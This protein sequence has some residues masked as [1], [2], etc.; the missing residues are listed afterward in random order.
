MVDHRTD[1][2]SLGVTLY[3]LLALRRPFEGDTREQLL[4]SVRSVEPVSLRRLDSGIPKDLQTICLKAMDKEPSGRYQTAAAMA[5]DL[6]RF[7]DGRPILSRPA[8]PLI[9]AY[10]W[11]RRH[12]ALSAAILSFAVACMLGAGLYWSVTSAREQK[13]A[14][15]LQA[16][17]TEADQLL[18]E[19]YDRIV[20]F[21]Y[22]I[23]REIYEKV[24]KAKMLGADPATVRLLKGILHFANTD[25]PAA[26]K[27]LKGVLAIEPTNA[28]ALYMLACTYDRMHKV[29]EADQFLAQADAIEEKT[30]GAWFFRGLAYHYRAPDEALE[31]Y[32]RARQMRISEGKEFLQ[33][34]LQLARIHNQRMYA[35]RSMDDFAAAIDA[36]KRL[37]EFK[38]YEYYPYYI[39]STAHRLAAEIYAG[40]RGTR[41]DSIV[42]HHYDEA[43]AAARQGQAVSP[44]NASA[45]SAE[46]LCLE[47][48]G[49]FEDAIAV[50]GKTIELGGNPMRTC[51]AHHYRWRL[52]FWMG[53]YEDALRD[54][55][56]HADCVGPDDKFYRHVY[57]LIVYAEMGDLQRAVE[58][59]YAITNDNLND[60][61]AVIWTAT[62]LNLLGRP[63]GA[64]E[65]LDRCLVNGVGNTGAEPW[66]TEEWVD[67]L[68]QLVYGDNTYDE[69][70][71]LVTDDSFQWKMRGEADFHAAAASLAVGDRK[72]ALEYLWKAFRSFDSEQAYTFHA[73]ILLEKM[74]RDSGWPGWIP[75][76]TLDFQGADPVQLE[77]IQ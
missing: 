59:A 19:A 28:E 69:L 31:S 35:T 18:Q 30:P 47:S 61:L 29:A 56:I 5:E 58:E 70:M 13:E 76:F 22:R 53:R 21:D 25:R 77:E 14:H 32:S 65:H 17:Q 39:L 45:Y 60:P 3:E 48:M 55:A 52:E 10:K 54:I 12:K 49:R 7:A 46:A 1:I 16:R 50:H 4:D 40:S 71:T 64:R 43:L 57:P 23:N 42:A 36:S 66:Q 11:A 33:A 62:C 41:S 72:T 67:S 75:V 8:G 74:E 44:Q 51:E 20:F 24:L 63:D 26:I 37:V 2:Y 73:K 6:R 34:T 68:W 9:R 38:V 15:L 27:E